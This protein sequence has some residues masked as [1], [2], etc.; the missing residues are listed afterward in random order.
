MAANLTRKKQMRLV[1]LGAFTSVIVSTQCYG[2]SV[3]VGADRYEY[4]T[5]V[6]EIK[7]DYRL[8]GLAIGGELDLSESVF[9][10]VGVGRW[11]DDISLKDSGS[12]DITSELKNVGVG[13][14]MGNW[15][16]FASYSVIEDEMEIIHGMNQEFFTSADIESNITHVDVSYQWEMGLWAHTLLVGAQRDQ[17]KIDADLD[18]PKMEL[19]DTTEANYANIKWSTDYYFYIAD[20][21]GIY[22]GAS[23]DW[24]DRLSGDSGD[25]NAGGPAPAGGPGGGGGGGGGNNNGGGG[26]RTSGDNGGIFGLYFAFDMDAN[27]SVDVNTTFGVAGD[28]DESAYSVTLTYTL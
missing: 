17:K 15:E 20:D 21:A 1:T 2:N 3:Y 10:Q 5:E 18:D 14:A 25:D 24:Y 6:S 13:Y 16:F 7:L 22:L 23:V 8:A 12:S 28:A 11:T 27:W 9:L 19:S 4:L 26:G